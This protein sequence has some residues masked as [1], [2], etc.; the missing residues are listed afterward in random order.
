MIET[1]ERK[2]YDLSLGVGQVREKIQRYN[3]EKKQREL[4]TISCRFSS[5]IHSLSSSHSGALLVPLVLQ[6]RERRSQTARNTSQRYKRDEDERERERERE[7][8]EEKRRG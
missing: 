6:S 2:P 5:L 3:E 1:T 4:D 7:R 8:G